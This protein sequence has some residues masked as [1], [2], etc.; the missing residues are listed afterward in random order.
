M[1]LRPLDFLIALSVPM[2]WGLGFVFAKG[3]IAHFPPIL[4]IALRFTV[5]ALALVWFVRAPVHLFGQI[6]VIA[7]VS[8]TIQYSMTFTALRYLDASTAGLVVQLETPLLVLMGWL[9]LGDRPS[10]R[11]QIGIAVSFAGV[12]LMTGDAKLQAAWQWLAL[13]ILGLVIWS[14]GQILVRKLGEVG[15]FTLVA[16]VSAFAA[17]Q[18]FLTSWALERDQ[19]EAVLAA[20]WR[21]W[22]TVVYLGLV[23][24]ALGYG[25]WYHL[26]GR[27]PVS[28]VGPF[29]LLIPVAT[30]AGGILLLGE[31]ASAEVLL[32]GAVIIAGVGFI[33]VERKRPIPPPP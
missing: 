25:L 14:F 15:G 33:L 20:D 26:L 3:A 9:V 4:L 18:L 31:R 29:L 23:M 6:F 5:T 28:Q 12:V 11:K 21:I 17:P 16:W 32:G 19:I 13:F 2:I 22:G 10:L 27:Y 1:A 7:L 8:A 30:L 24:T